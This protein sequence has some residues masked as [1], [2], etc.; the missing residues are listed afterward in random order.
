[1]TSEL[2]RAD[3]KLMQRYAEFHYINAA[4]TREEAR[5]LYAVLWQAVGFADKKAYLTNLLA[6]AQRESPELGLQAD[7]VGRLANVLANVLRKFDF[8]PPSSGRVP[9]TLVEAR[10]APDLPQLDTEAGKCTRCGEVIS[11]HVFGLPDGLCWGCCTS[12]ERDEALNK[13]V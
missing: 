8:Q 5:L 4:L 13:N 9:T 6:D 10:D 1:M 7:E 3:P 12:E 2:E 11:T